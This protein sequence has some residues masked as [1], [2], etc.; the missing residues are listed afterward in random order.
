MSIGSTATYT[1]DSGY[2]IVGENTRTCQ[3]DGSWSGR[4]PICRI[5]RC[6]G[7][8]SPINGR[9]SI[10]DNTVGGIATYT[11]NSG[12]SLSGSGTR[13]CQNDGSWSGSTP[14]CSRVVCSSL[15]NP[16][17]GRVTFS[18]GVFVGSRA[19]YTCDIGYFIIGEDMRT[20][21]TDGMWS[22]IAPSCRIIRCGGLS[23]PSNG[24]VFISEDTV[25]GIATY[26]C[27]S[28]Y[29]L[30]GSETRICQNDGSW[31][32]DAPVCELQG[33]F[34]NRSL[35]ELLYIYIILYSHNTVMCSN[36]PAPSNGRVDQRGNQ[37]GDTA[38]YFCNTNYELSGDR[39]RICQNDGSWSGSAPTCT[40][41]VC[42]SLPNPSNGQVTFSSGVFVGSRATYTCNNGYFIDGQSTRT[43]QGDG[44][45]TGSAPICRIIRCGGLSNPS[46][47]Q[48]SITDNTVGGRATYTCNSGYDLVGI[49]IRFCQNDGSWSGDAP[50]CEQ[51]SK[52]II[53]QK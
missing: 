30:F 23:S 9:V 5:V 35:F 49:E 34:K 16:T 52:L 44:S 12:Y 6:G 46:N 50:V 48:V 32:G 18:S 39:T 53:P 47:G 27:N 29:D 20:C 26:R 36:L 21:Q 28:G 14:T 37:P 43:C 4:A 41:I 45:W 2:F 15:S 3:E 25:G 7:L 24:Q 22:G 13:I 40:R 8:N 11:C 1:C 38:T 31:S 17:N 19:T 10:S 51:Q 42:A 33:R